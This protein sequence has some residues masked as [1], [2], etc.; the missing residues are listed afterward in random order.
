M[1]TEQLIPKL[2]SE[3][4]VSCVSREKIM[5]AHRTSMPVNG[6]ISATALQASAAFCSDCFATFV[7]SRAGSMCIHCGGDIA[8]LTAKVSA[9]CTRFFLHGRTGDS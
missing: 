1:Y 3:L 9:K 4:V 7:S 8:E 5:C 2:Q 6:S